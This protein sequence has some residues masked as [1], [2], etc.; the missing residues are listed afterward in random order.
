MDTIDVDQYTEGTLS[1][2]R[3]SLEQA[4]AV[5]WPGHKRLSKARSIEERKQLVDEIVTSIV[6]KF[7]PGV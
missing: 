7:P 5:A 3:R 1:W 2:I 6:A 4:V